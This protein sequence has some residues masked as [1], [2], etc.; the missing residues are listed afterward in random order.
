MTGPQKTLLAIALVVALALG[1]FIWFVVNWQAGQ[2]N[3]TSLNPTRSASPFFGSQ[4][5][6][7]LGQS[8]GSVAAT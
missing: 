7:G 6:W 5:P 8:P 3:T 2:T 1:G 4:I